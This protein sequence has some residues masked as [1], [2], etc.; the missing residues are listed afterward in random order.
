VPE[1]HR[2]AALV[3]IGLGERQRFLM[4]S[5]A[6]DRTTITARNRRPWRLSPA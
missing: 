6:R 5:P 3:K 1:K 4:R 2:S